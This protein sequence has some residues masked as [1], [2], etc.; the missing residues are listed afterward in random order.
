MHKVNNNDIHIRNLDYSDVDE[1]LSLEK[2]VWGEQAATRDMLE[3]RIET[4]QTGQLIAVTEQNMIAGYVSFFK[5]NEMTGANSNWDKITDKGMIKKSHMHNGKYIF[6]VS[7]TGH[8][9]KP[10]LG[11]KL[12]GKGVEFCFDNDILGIYLGSRVPG[13]RK[14]SNQYSITDWVF[15]NNKKSRDKEIRY[16]QKYDWE[17]IRILPEYFDDPESMDYGVLMLKKIDI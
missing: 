9:N 16:Y 7:L 15:N 17:I 10:G 11:E 5:V 14:A 3:S 13:Y 1:L 6:G 12:I 2:H 8:P 4:F